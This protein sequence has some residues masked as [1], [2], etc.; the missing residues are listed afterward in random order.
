[1]PEEGAPTSPGEI[2]VPTYD[3]AKFSQITAWNWKNLDP[4]VV[5]FSIYIFPWDLLWTG[6]YHLNY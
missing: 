4:I 1:M 2:S 3:F 6:W 5:N